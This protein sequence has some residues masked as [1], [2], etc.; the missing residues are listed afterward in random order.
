[1]ILLFRVFFHKDRH[2][3]LG[4]IGHGQTAGAEKDPLD[5]PERPAVFP[6]GLHDALVQQGL[7]DIAVEQR[8][9]ADPQGPQKER[10]L[11]QRLPPAKAPDLIQLQCFCV[12]EYHTRTHEEHQLE[13]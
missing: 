3:E 11:Q 9:A 2:V 10:R 12:H 13:Q 1:M 5:D 4:H 8:D 7:A 6:G